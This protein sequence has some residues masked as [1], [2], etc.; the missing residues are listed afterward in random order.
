MKIKAV[1]LGLVVSGALLFGKEADFRVP[2]IEICK[3]KNGV[4]QF[5]TDIDPQKELD[6]IDA[7]AFDLT[8]KENAKTFF[9][10]VVL[11]HQKGLE[12]ANIALLNDAHINTTVHA[13]RTLQKQVARM[14]A[15]LK[16]LHDQIS[17][18]SC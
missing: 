8:N 15:E 4:T 9:K 11:A 7:S 18:F 16:V 10:F 17:G 2:K 14:E 1:M 13:V 6:K 3:D 5:R 12:V